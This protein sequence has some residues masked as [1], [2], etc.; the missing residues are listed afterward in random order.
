MIVSRVPLFDNL[1]HISFEDQCEDVVNVKRLPPGDLDLRWTQV[2]S[3]VGRW[4][5]RATCASGLM[6]SRL[7]RSV[8]M[9]GT[10]LPHAGQPSQ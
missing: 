4:S 10:G 2:D 9:T 3:V 5:S 6:R 8:G 1:K 7:A